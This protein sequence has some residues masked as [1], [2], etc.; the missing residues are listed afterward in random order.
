MSVF[1]DRLHFTTQGNFDI[2][3]ITEEVKKKLSQSGMQNGLLTVFVPGST[4]AVTTIEY[5]PG[6]L[7]D[8]K[9]F[10]D[11][12]IPIKNDYNHNVAWQ[13]NNGYSHLRASFVGASVSVPFC[14]G[15][16][17]LGTWQQIIF[18]DF[19]CRNREREIIVQ[20]IGE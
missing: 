7:D 18:I 6:L 8:L 19:D 12:I 3:D 1:S 17:T 13:D 4:G 15:E 10:F 5:E 11:K 16:L 20:I 2:H 14:K 9:A